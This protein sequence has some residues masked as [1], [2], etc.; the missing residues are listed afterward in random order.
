MT[1][2]Q[3]K[4]AEDLI[5]E[6]KKNNGVTNWKNFRNANSINGTEMSLVIKAL[7]ELNIIENFVGDTTIIRLTEPGWGFPGFNAQRNIAQTQKSITEEKDKYDLLTK[8]WIYKTRLFP[9]FVSFIAL[10][11]SIFAYFKKPEKEK[12]ATQSTQQQT[13]PATN[14]NT[15]LPVDTAQKITPK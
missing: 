6:M 8:K 4:I 10:I 12:P 9:Y 1:P 13:T 14:T 15:A 5:S 2:E 7:R 3:E 11:V